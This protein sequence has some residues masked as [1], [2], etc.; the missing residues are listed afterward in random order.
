MSP[1][2]EPK[3]MSDRFCYCV[4]ERPPQSSQKG[5]SS[6]ALPS[7]LK[8]L[9]RLLTA[10]HRTLGASQMGM[11]ET[12]TTPVERQFETL[13]DRC[14]R[15][16]MLVQRHQQPVPAPHRMCRPD[17]GVCRVQ[18]KM[19]EELR[20]HHRP[21]SLQLTRREGEQ[22]LHGATVDLHRA[23]CQPKSKISAGVR[24]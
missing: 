9:R 6:L 10:R 13:M 19:S 7:V 8:P 23:S 17:R 15:L 3:T 20:W 18:I 2:G 22:M 14:R 1:V 16:D 5:A 4:E 12:T 21:D 11:S 24:R